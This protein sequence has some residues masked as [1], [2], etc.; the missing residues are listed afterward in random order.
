[1]V[2]LN[3]VSILRITHLMSLS[4][5]KVRPKPRW[6]LAK[7]ARRPTPSKDKCDGD[8]GKSSVAQCIDQA[9]QC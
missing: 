8:K 9:N 2:S 4:H 1:M 7:D 3:D 6:F 5:I